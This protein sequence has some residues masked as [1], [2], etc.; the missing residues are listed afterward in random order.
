RR[1]VA[2]ES[3]AL[4]TPRL[5]RL[6][7]PP[8]PQPGEKAACTTLVPSLAAA[9]P[10]LA[11]SDVVSAGTAGPSPSRPRSPMRYVA[12]RRRVPR[13]HSATSTP[14]PVPPTSRF[15]TS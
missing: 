10:A 3:P 13:S 4:V 9:N 7:P 8:P 6:T 1:S 12:V 11:V 2:H 14:P 5:Q 15:R